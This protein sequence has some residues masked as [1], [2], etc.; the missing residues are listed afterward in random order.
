MFKN[1]FQ[2]GFL[3]IL[4][5]IGSKPLQ[6]WTKKVCG[7]QQVVILFVFLM[8]IINVG[9]CDVEFACTALISMNGSNDNFFLLTVFFLYFRIFHSFLVFLSLFCCL[10]SWLGLKSLNLI[11]DHFVSLPGDV[12]IENTF[13]GSV[14]A[15]N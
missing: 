6:L 12:Y 10:E 11:W 8:V 9:K 15:N 1:T 2:S 3:S 7:G 14:C 4:Y 13:G 5:S